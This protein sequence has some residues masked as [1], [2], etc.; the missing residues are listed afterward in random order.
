[1]RCFRL[2]FD[3]II[4]FFAAGAMSLSAAEMQKA[5][6]GMAN[7]APSAAIV[8]GDGRASSGLLGLTSEQ[9][10]THR[11]LSEDSAV[12][13]ALGDV[14]AVD[15]PEPTALFLAGFAGCMLLAVAQRLRGS[16]PRLR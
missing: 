2:R 13:V 14:R 3:C 6:V 8:A 1:M 16:K 11:T 7:F 4:A 15:V 5:G 9:G 12:N 10:D